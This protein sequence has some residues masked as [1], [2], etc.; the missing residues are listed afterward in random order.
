MKRIINCVFCFILILTFAVNVY[1]VEKTADISTPRL[2]VTDY[3]LD[4]DILTPGVKSKIVLTIKNMSKT[5]NVK[6]ILFTLSD[7]E[8]EIIVE[9]TGTYYVYSI[10]AGKSLTW[11]TAVTAIKTAKGGRHELN[12]S[13]EYENADGAPFSATSSVYADVKENKTT[14]KKADDNSKP[15]LMITGY[16]IENGFITPG[17][18]STLTVTVT[19]KSKTRAVKNILFSLTDAEKE[20]VPDGTGTLFVDSIG[21]GKS[22]TWKT[23]LTAIHSAAQSRHEL[24]I[25][26]EYEDSNGSPYSLA[27]SI[28]ADVR[29][30]ASLDFSGAVLPKKVVQGETVSL[31]VILM[32]TGKSEIINAKTDY[33]IDGFISGGTSFAGT[34]AAGESKSCNVNLQVSKEVLGDVKGKIIFSY[35]DAFG[36]KYTEEQAVSTLIEKKAE[37]SKLETKTEDKKNPQ[38]WLFIVIGITV[39]IGIGAAVPILIYRKKQRQQDEAML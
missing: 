17:E 26:A 10:P 16:E 9:G 33:E 23:E 30:T 22:F 34:I 11:E 19:N 4:T 14:E 3:K 5:T 27:A 1:A 15:H 12:F 6:N 21:A 13:A 24:N 31:N 20:I 38:W 18:K 35:E 37:E 2:M 36:E 25:S 8:N 7:S 32:N 28:Y 39:G 29:Q